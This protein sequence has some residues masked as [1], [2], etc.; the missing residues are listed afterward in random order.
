MPHKYSHKYATVF[1][2]CYLGIKRD[3]Q[4]TASRILSVFYV[5]SLKKKYDIVL[6]IYNINP[7]INTHKKYFKRLMKAY[8]IAK[9]CAFI[10]VTQIFFTN[11]WIRATSVARVIESPST[12]FVQFVLTILMLKMKCN[13][14]R[15]HP[16][17]TL[18]LLIHARYIHMRSWGRSIRPLPLAVGSICKERQGEPETLIHL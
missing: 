8:S 18:S 13:A 14:S 6:N 5:K 9:F 10:D 4:K 15:R 16:C 7:P 3:F 17:G 1:Y 2:Q 12:L 11:S